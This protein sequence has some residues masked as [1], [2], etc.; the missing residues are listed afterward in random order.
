MKLTDHEWIAATP[1]QTWNTLLAPAQ[2]Q[3]CLHDCRHVEQISENEYHV[4]FDTSQG[5]STSQFD[6]VILIEEAQAPR[7]LRVVFDGGGRHAGLAI[8][9]ADITLEPG[10]HGGTRLSY[11]LEAAAGGALA[12][13][14]PAE[15]EK[16]ARRHLEGFFLRLNAMA[17]QAPGADPAPPVTQDT[18]RQR[19]LGSWLVAVAVVA[20][21]VAYFVLLRP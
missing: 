6:G 21:V 19:G 18:T 16:R 8:G 7:Q 14:G 20:A 15:L 12:R 9:H 11:Q 2:L 13:L 3:R 17:P 10:A 5:G 1:W 4:R